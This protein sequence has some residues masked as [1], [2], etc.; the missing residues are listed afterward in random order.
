MAW[1]MIINGEE[2][3]GKEQMVVLDPC[4][5]QTAG[6]V[7]IS[8]TEQVNMAIEGAKKAQVLICIGCKN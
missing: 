2:L 7:A 8:T 4:T 5:G 1:P 3:Q 6:M